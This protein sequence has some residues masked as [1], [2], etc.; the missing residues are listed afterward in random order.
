MAQ[1]AETFRAHPNIMG[2]L[3]CTINKYKKLHLFCHRSTVVVPLEV[4]WICIV[5]EVSKEEFLKDF[6]KTFKAESPKVER[7]QERRGVVT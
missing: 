1:R 5:C 6:F 3:L 4:L 2:C 7:D